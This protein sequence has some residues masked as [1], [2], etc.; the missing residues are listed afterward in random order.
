MKT[1]RILP[2][3]SPFLNGSNSVLITKLTTPV[4]GTKKNLSL[5]KPALFGGSVDRLTTISNWSTELLTQSEPGTKSIQVQ[6]MLRFLKQSVKMLKW[7]SNLLQPCLLLVLRC[8]QSLL[9]E[10]VIQPCRWMNIHTK[11]KMRNHMTS[12]NSKRF[13]I[14]CSHL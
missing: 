2:H 8:C 9:S 7:H 11:F 13:Y 1:V 3:N 12:T 5:L 6:M 10:I 14:K 4:L